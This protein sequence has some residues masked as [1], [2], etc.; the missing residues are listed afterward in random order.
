MRT[1]TVT[2]VFYFQLLNIYRDVSVA[3][4]TQGV[5]EFVS[6]RQTG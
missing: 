1:L 4:I 3:F 2:F 5:V 6:D